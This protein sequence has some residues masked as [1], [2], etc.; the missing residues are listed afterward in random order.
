MRRIWP[1]GAA[2]ARDQL[3]VGA[4][5]HA[6]AAERRDNLVEIQPSVGDQ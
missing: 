2:Q 1:V 4:E 5:C 3:A 6:S